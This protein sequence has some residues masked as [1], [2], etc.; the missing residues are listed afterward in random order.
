[1][2]FFTYL[3]RRRAAA[4]GVLS[5]VAF[6]LSGA[7]L[8]GGS[9]TGRATA[10]GVDPGS[11]ASIVSGLDKAGEGPRF[12]T[13]VFG[14]Q[15]D[16]LPVPNVDAVVSF[17]DEKTDPVGPYPLPQTV[18]WQNHT[19]HATVGQIGAV[20]GIAHSEGNPDATSAA[21]KAPRSFYGAYLKSQTRFGPLGPGGIY[22]RNGNAVTSYVTIPNAGGDTTSEAALGG[23]HAKTGTDITA[24]VGKASLG[25]L[26]IDAEEHF[27]YVTNLN[28]RLVYQVDTWT[29]TAPVAL[30]KSPNNCADV[31]DQQPFGL[32][33][34]GST[35]YLGTMCSAETSKDPAKLGADVWAYNTATKTWAAAPVMHAVPVNGSFGGFTP[36]SDDISNDVVAN[37]GAMLTGIDVDPSGSMVLGLRNRAGDIGTTS[38]TYKQIDGSGAVSITPP[39]GAGG[40]KSFIEVDP[41]VANVNAAPVAPLVAPRTFET[42]SSA[43]GA[44]VS[45]PFTHDGKPGSEIAASQRDVFSWSAQ[46]VLWFD[47]ANPGPL[48]I[49]AGEEANH[50]S[51]FSKAS[52]LGDLELLATWRAFGDRVWLDANGDG[53]Q[54]SGENGIAGVKL[55]LKSTCT[56]ATLKS[57]TTDAQGN[58]SFYVKPFEA[59]TVVADATNFAAGGA[60]LNQTYT[61]QVGGDGTNNSKADL[62]TGCVAVAK[63][64]REDVN[65]TYDIGVKPLPK[66]TYAVGDRVWLD[67]N[68]NGAFDDTEKGVKDVC[69]QA[70]LG[71]K[72]VGAKVLTNAEGYYVI[73]ALSTGDYTLAFTCLPDGYTF[74]TTTAAGVADD[75]NS[76]P[77]ATGVTR[78]VKLD[79]TA[80]A[81]TDA[82]RTALGPFVGDKIIRT[83]DAGLKAPAETRFAVGDKVWLD[84][85]HNGRQDIG[86]SPVE[87]VSVTLFASGSTTPPLEKITNKDGFYIFDNLAKGSYTVKF[88]TPAGYRLTTPNAAGI[89]ADVNSDA[90]ADGTTAS[91]VLDAPSNPLALN[92]TTQV[93]QGKV[94]NF[95]NAT[96]DAGLYVP[97]A[98]G[99]VVWS[100]TNGD[101]IQNA[102]EPGVP[103]VKVTLTSGG[104]A[105]KDANGVP[106]APVVTAADGTYNFDNLLPG[107]Y[108]VTFTDTPAGLPFVA[109]KAPNSNP[110]NDSDVDPT[111]A[112]VTVV[113]PATGGAL[114]VTTPADG[115][116]TATFIDKTVDAGLVAPAYSIGNRVWFDENDNGIVDAG[117][118]GIGAV[119]VRLFTAAAD[120]G[121]GD[122]VAVQDTDTNGFYRFTGLT[123]GNYVVRVEAKNFADGGHLVGF[124]S[125]YVDEASPNSDGDLNDNGLGELGGPNPVTSGVITLGPGA[126]E[127]TGELDLGPGGQGASDA[128]A[129][130]TVDFGF[131]VIVDLGITKTLVSKELGK[132]STITWKIEVAN[133]SSVALDGAKVVD[134][135]PITVKPGKA[136]GDGW[137]CAFAGQEL[138]CVHAGPIAA[139]ADSSFEVNGEVLITN[140]SIV[141][142]A[143]V[144]NPR[145]P[146]VFTANDADQVSA[147]VL[148]AVLVGKLPRTGSGLWKKAAVIADLLATLGAVLVIH[149]T[150][151]RRRRALGFFSR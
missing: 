147:T 12:E 47:V 45:V 18:A 151:T 52:G 114:V 29:N 148:T 66:V 99:D 34:K 46:G 143:T 25:D 58:Y 8:V 62:G 126:S 140:G 111:T 49:A 150:A 84:A 95:I 82:D 149:D 21:A 19:P 115:T 124:L 144:S 113:L 125:S 93:P 109:P 9:Q 134:L 40:W 6:G 17:G 69:V 54:T 116:L 65:L 77:T 110:T 64:S 96:I 123:A 136:S 87:N 26:E 31:A 86:E 145:G 79:A 117:E 68:G 107:T 98:I 53:L 44:V 13:T 92:M 73:G 146:D 56:S 33:V 142:S 131:T 3:P 38:A 128:Q 24:K 129:N 83:I 14:Y 51:N 10:A 102:S 20:Y 133:N 61:Q 105:A 88:A 130:M 119:T 42:G 132:G 37:R 67:A 141:N 22:V 74:T 43:L 59:Y 39:N 78:V 120:G 63:A 5:L 32:K 81:A 27:L 11:V 23:L 50:V 91:F 55:N 90:T 112:S 76:D 122:S 106:V 89:A 104:A 85:N 41:N 2:A 121:I 7:N 4:V 138:T 71:G 35:V 1:M 137:S 118:Y 72:E 75:H 57:V 100:D 30:A 16:T 48:T 70:S 101:G 28:D 36:W 60:L 97:L 127:P 135:L 80:P 108:V 139:G 15:E 103:G 94:A